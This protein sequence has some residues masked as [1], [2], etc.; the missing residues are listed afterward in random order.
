MEWSVKCHVFLVHISNVT[1]LAPEQ[2]PV[3]FLE[4]G[5]VAKPSGRSQGVKA[6]GMIFHM[7]L[8]KWG[9]FIMLK[10]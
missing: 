7:M 4:T 1:P 6:S 5:R 2:V 8:E 10:R 3:I 9:Q